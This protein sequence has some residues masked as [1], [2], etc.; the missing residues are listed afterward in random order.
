MSNT[1][2]GCCVATFPASKTDTQLPLSRLCRSSPAPLKSRCTNSFMM[3]KSLPRCRTSRSARPPTILHGAAK[4]KTHG[5]RRSSAASS[6]AWNKEIWEWCCSWH[7]RWRGG[8]PFE[9]NCLEAGHSEAAYRV[10][11]SES[12]PV[13]T[14]PAPLPGN[15]PEAFNSLAL[16]LPAAIAALFVA[17]PFPVPA[18]ALFESRI[19]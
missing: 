1:V 8:R 15:E 7:R 18:T 6:A 13:S 10:G 3:A 19:S 14:V 4:A 9:P 11:I 5:C 17:K 16:F 2:L 12:C